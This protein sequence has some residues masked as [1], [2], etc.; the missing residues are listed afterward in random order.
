MMTTIGSVSI[1]PKI[2][3]ILYPNPQWDEDS[4]KHDVAL[5]K[6]TT[7]IPEFSGSLFQ[8]HDLKYIFR[9]YNANMCT[10]YSSRKYDCPGPG[11][12]GIRFRGHRIDFVYNLIA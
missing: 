10:R 5:M 9:V 12:E 6:L 3:A 8:I 11:P 1:F 4:Y 2:S 7:P